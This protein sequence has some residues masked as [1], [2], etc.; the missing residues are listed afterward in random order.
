MLS[1]VNAR[2]LVRSIPIAQ[3]AACRSASDG[4]GQ[5]RMP[6]R[7]RGFAASGSFEAQ[8]ADA[9]DPSFWHGIHIADAGLGRA[10]WRGEL[11]D[12]AQRAAVEAYLRPWRRGASR[13]EFASVLEQI[14]F[15]ITVLGD[16]PRKPDAGRKK[17]RDALDAILAQLHSA[18]GVS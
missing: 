16:G 13:L 1:I 18:T 17:L 3:L 11:D 8:A 5:V 2:I 15:V 12:L 7:R 14:G 6:G 4:A 10:L 9:A